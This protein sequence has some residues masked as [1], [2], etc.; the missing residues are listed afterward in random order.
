MNGTR[1]KNIADVNKYI[2]GLNNGIIP[3]TESLMIT[4]AE[5]LKEIIFLGL[6][7]TEG[8]NAK[9]NPSS[10]IHDREALK[11]LID[12]SV[13]VI[14]QGYLSWMKILSGLQEK[15]SLFQTQLS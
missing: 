10:T 4:P 9:D 12:A 14:C 3:E 7:K 11:K 2:A 5:S 8:I 15:G 1:T 6:R 13:E